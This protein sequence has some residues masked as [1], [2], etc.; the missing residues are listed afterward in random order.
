MAVL[1]LERYQV[2]RAVE[3]QEQ[4]EAILQEV[5]IM[6]QE[7][8]GAMDCLQIL[9]EEIQ[10]AQAAAAADHIT[11]AVPLII[12]AAQQALAALVQEEGLRQ[13]QVVLLEEVELMALVQAAVAA[14][15]PTLL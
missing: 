13:E 1:G 2:C 8:L 3:A 10:P 4:Q 15:G 6:A 7:R 11:M 5:V 12:Q 14:Q 9:T